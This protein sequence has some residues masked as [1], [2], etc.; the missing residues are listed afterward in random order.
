MRLFLKCHYDYDRSFRGFMI[1][2]I[3]MSD[4]QERIFPFGSM[5]TCDVCDD[6]ISVHI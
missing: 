2:S 6:N 4:L 3:M 5:V 1:H